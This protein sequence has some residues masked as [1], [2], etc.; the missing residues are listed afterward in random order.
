[1][2]S[3][4]SS[5]ES[6]PN[7]S[8]SN[9]LANTMVSMK[10]E[11]HKGLYD[12]RQHPDSLPVRHQPPALKKEEIAKIS[13]PTTPK[14]QKGATRYNSHVE[15]GSAPTR[16]RMDFEDEVPDLDEAVA[17]HQLR[18]CLLYTSRCV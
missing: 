10:T 18:A 14:E 11:D 17:H 8:R 7:L 4:S 16:G 12:H 1:M 5:S 6:S 3:S 13:K 15:V 2:S 9:S